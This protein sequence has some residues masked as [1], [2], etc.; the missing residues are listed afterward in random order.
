MAAISLQSLLL[1]ALVQTATVAGSLKTLALLRGEAP[2]DHLGGSMAGVGDV[3]RDALADFLV[4]DARDG[5][6]PGQRRCQLYLG[7]QTLDMPSLV[8][9]Q[10][11]VD[12]GGPTHAD[13]DD[14]FGGAVDGGHD[15]NGDGNDDMV[16]TSPGWFLGTGKAYVYAGGALPDTVPV[17]AIAGYGSSWMT[18]P[19]M[20]ELRGVMVSDVN[21]DGFD[22]L[23]CLVGPGTPDA[24]VYLYYGGAPMDSV[25][26]V[27]FQGPGSPGLQLGTC[28]ADGDL[29]ADG[30]IDL[31]VGSYW[32]SHISYES[33]AAWIYFGDTP[34]D[35][36]PDL[37]LRPE[38]FCAGF[39]A[40]VP[41][42]LNGDGCDDLVVSYGYFVYPDGY[43]RSAVFF[44][45]SGVDSI[46]DLTLERENPQ[47]SPTLLAGGDINL[48]GFADIVAPSQRNLETPHT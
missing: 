2:G 4:G 40:C 25:H 47:G 36:I 20:T 9:W 42:D 26:D 46:P 48:D 41:G 24:G 37:T 13:D 14:H 17:I 15:L 3:N 5:W 1:I 28:L 16:I 39:D 34:F 29:N 11:E 8:L 6:Y 45:G 7:G 43:L 12:T 21:G 35:T 22:E 30:R 31:I 10:S 19:W 23:A 33:D 18:L 32:A 27:G 38:D 44:G